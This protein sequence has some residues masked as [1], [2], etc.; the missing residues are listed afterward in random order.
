MTQVKIKRVYEE[1]VHNHARIL[2][3]FLESGL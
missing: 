1:P 2:Q 3:S